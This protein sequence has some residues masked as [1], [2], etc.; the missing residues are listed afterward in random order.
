MNQFIILFKKRKPLFNDFLSFMFHVG[1]IG[2]FILWASLKCFIII[3]I[4]PLLTLFHF[5]QIQQKKNW[6]HLNTF[7]QKI[8]KLAEYC[9]VKTCVI[10]LDWSTA[11][12][13]HFMSC[14]DLFPSSFGYSKPF[15]P[16]SIKTSHLTP[17]AAVSLT[18]L[19][20]PVRPLTSS[21][22]TDCLAL[23]WL[24]HTSCSCF[25][26]EAAIKNMRV[27]FCAFL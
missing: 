4:S 17:S 12:Y 1:R 2:P 21:R 23:S 5:F 16:G 20:L 14:P 8:I 24:F 18:V 25:M 7:L 6:W 27:T 3:Q 10:T 13:T 26:A 15:L 11:W 22:Q 19:P 9:H